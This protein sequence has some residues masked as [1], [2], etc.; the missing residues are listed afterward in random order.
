MKHTYTYNLAEFSQSNIYDSSFILSR[1]KRKVN[2]LQLG[3]G[4]LVIAFLAI[5]ITVAIVKLMPTTQKSVSTT[6]KKGGKV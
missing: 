5:L 2:L 3:I 4:C 6:E 1:N